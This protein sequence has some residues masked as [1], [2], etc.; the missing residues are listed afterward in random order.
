MDEALQQRIANLVSTNNVV[1]FMKGTRTQPTCGFSATVVQI[2]DELLPEYET[3]N[4]L[5]DPALRDGIKQF[6]NWP[7]IP[8]LFVAGKLVGGCDIVKELKVSGALSALLAL[9]P[10]SPKVENRDEIDLSKVC[11]CGGAKA[12]TSGQA[13]ETSS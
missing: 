6:S 12:A 7:T 2:L 13:A 1:L 8:Q 5:T 11:R 10:D 4:V 3:V 9:H